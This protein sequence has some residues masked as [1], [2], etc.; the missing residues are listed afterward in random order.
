MYH[1]WYAV[2]QSTS[3]PAHVTSSYVWSNP[4]PPGQM[5]LWGLGALPNGPPISCRGRDKLPHCTGGSV[6]RQSSVPGLFFTHSPLLPPL[7]F[8]SQIPDDWIGLSPSYRASLPQCKPSRHPSQTIV[9]S[10]VPAIST[11]APYQVDPTKLVDFDQ[12]SLF[13]TSP[14]PPQPRVLSRC[15]SYGQLCT[16]SC[17]WLHD[18]TCVAVVINSDRQ[19]PRGATSTVPG[20]VTDNVT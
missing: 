17:G 6:S 18:S 9:L 20:T 19:C 12:K 16:H 13:G 10:Y 15:Y 1:V 4:H 3:S 8:V 11:M 14:P 2:A 7:F 5:T